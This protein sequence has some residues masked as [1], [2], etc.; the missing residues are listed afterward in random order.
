MKSDG[1]HLA[2]LDPR[3]TP[4]WDDFAE[5]SCAATVFHT[6][7]WANVLAE[8]YAFEPRYVAAVTTSGRVLAGI[9]IMLVRSPLTGHRMIGLP[10]SDAC[11]PLL[12]GFPEA[13]LVVDAALED[14]RGNGCAFLELRGAD[15]VEFEKADFNRFDF[16]QHQVSLEPSLDEIEAGLSSAKRRAR[17][18]ALKEGV[19]VIR[20]FSAADLKTFYGLYIGTR[21]KHGL[22]PAPF[23]F[24]ENIWRVLIQPGQGCLLMAMWKGHIIAI[25]LVLWYRD[26]L[27]YKFNVWD[28][29]FQEV[30]P[31]DL[32]L[33]EAIRL[34]K[35]LSLARF[36]LGRCEPENEGLR[37]FKMGWS[38]KESVLPY[39]F[40]PEVRGFT[41]GAEEKASHRIAATVIRHTP[42][43]IL[44]Q[45]GFLY[46]HLA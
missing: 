37:R 40:Y 3:S 12:D 6:S 42:R 18:R 21:R 43:S 15:G 35:E 8:T 17:N 22:P 19:E 23:A 16:V 29:R 27:H 38:A 1:F 44:A 31:N 45:A 33:W 4:A 26:C 11:P 25:D 13:R 10:F 24:F 2:V 9:P 34:G 30:R 46:R 14:Y 36:D 20:S 39:Q 32:L 28:T 7:N 5:S 41:A